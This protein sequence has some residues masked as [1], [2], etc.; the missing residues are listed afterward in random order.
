MIRINAVEGTY[1]AKWERGREQGRDG[2]TEGGG[3][4]AGGSL[5]GPSAG[6]EAICDVQEGSQGLYVVQVSVKC[7]PRVLIDFMME[8]SQNLQEEPGLEGS[9]LQRSSW[10]LCSQRRCRLE[11]PALVKRGVP[12]RE[13]G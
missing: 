1:D 6:R 10:T 4:G 11:E 2:P 5:K 3:E 13:E 8:A 9:S 12:S 7:L